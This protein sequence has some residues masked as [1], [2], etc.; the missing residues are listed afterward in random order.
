MNS[1][2]TVLLVVYLVVNMADPGINT[3][4]SKIRSGGNSRQTN[5]PIINNYYYFGT[6]SQVYNDNSNNINQQQ[7]IS[8]QPAPLPGYNQLPQ[9]SPSYGVVQS[10]SSSVASKSQSSG[11]ADFPS[12]VGSG[13]HS[14]IAATNS[15][16]I[17][18]GLPTVELIRDCN[19]GSYIYFLDERMH[20]RN[21][22]AAKIVIKH[23]CDM[24]GSEADYERREYRNRWGWM[25]RGRCLRAKDIQ[26]LFEESQDYLGGYRS[27]REI[28]R[29]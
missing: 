13:P 21:V 4:Y 12:N 28:I 6:G 11:G 26:K 23:I 9:S 20:G 29:P 16:A 7:A 25:I 14:V 19:D 5:A 17:R 15:A 18:M 10:D 27:D 1:I 8:Q 3:S 24:A 2:A 22:L